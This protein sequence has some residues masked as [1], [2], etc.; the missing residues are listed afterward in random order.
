[1]ASWR[2][3]LAAYDVDSQ[4]ARGYTL[5]LTDDGHV[6]RSAAALAPGS[7]L[8]TRFADGR[9]QSDVRRIELTGSGR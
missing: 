6:V 1:M 3:L 7:V 9:V 8:V 4:L 2:R 5:T